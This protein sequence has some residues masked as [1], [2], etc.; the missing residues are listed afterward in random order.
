LLLLGLWL[1]SPTYSREVT[2]AWDASQ[3]SRTT[4]YRLHW[5]TSSRVY[6]NHLDVGNVTT[7][8]GDL[9]DLVYITATAYGT[10]GTTES[11]FSNEI[12]L[13]PRPPPATQVVAAW[14]EVATMA[15]PTTGILDNFNRASLGANWTAYYNTISIQSSTVLRG[16]TASDQNV[17]GWNV[18]TYGP[19]V[20]LYATIATK[21][22]ESIRL[23]F[24]RGGGGFQ[25]YFVEA[26]T[27]AGN[28]NLR[29]VDNPGETTL[30]TV[31]SITWAS[32]DAFG[33]SAIGSTFKLYRKPSG[34]SWGQVGADATDTTY[35]GN[36]SFTLDI[37]NDGAANCRLDDFGGGTVVV[38]GLSIPVAMANFRQRR[39]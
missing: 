30:R 3:D 34:G 17:A 26:E 32:G 38:S 35:T 14:A 36:S 23:W 12:Q 21:S 7:W 8:T 24:S 37:W 16:D 19:D 9:N 2:L 39:N 13:L 5:G 1:P 27:S 29:R 22:A 20:E 6:T 31:S 33:V 18:A 28:L 11:V 15:F 25:G 10:G 4:G